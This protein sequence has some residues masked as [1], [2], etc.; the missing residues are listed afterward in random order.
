MQLDR[1]VA[2]HLYANY[3]YIIK[4]VIK[5]QFV[6]VLEFP[7][8]YN[9]RLF[10]NVKMQSSLRSTSWSALWNSQGISVFV[11]LEFDRW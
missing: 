7:L 6:D 4:I 5:I 3:Q 8:K 10:M 9:V 1:M 11:Y 2:P